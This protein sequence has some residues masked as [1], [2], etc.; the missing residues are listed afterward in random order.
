MFRRSEQNVS[1]WLILVKCTVGRRLFDVLSLAFPRQA[2]RNE[3]RFNGKFAAPSP[4]WWLWYLSTKYLINLISRKRKGSEVVKFVVEWQDRT[5][6]GGWLVGDAKTPMIS[7]EDHESDWILAQNDAETILVLLEKKRAGLAG[8]RKTELILFLSIDGSKLI[9]WREQNAM[10]RGWEWKSSFGR[11]RWCKGLWI[12]DVV[13]SWAL[14]RYANI[15]LVHW[16]DW[17]RRRTGL[18]HEWDGW[19]CLG[20]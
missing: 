13:I 20:W 8:R 6:T 19:K 11:Q 5:V 18:G 16:H 2:A 14:R 10:L 17:V 9:L 12:P 3:T 1:R 4:W 15:T 7:P